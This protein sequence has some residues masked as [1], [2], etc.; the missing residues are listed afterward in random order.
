M[1]YNTYKKNYRRKRTYRRRRPSSAYSMAKRSLYMA[2]KAQGQKELKYAAFP[3]VSGDVINTG[4]I[5]SL[6]SIAQGDTNLTREG[7]VVYPT[8]LRMKFSVTNAGAPGAR[9]FRVIVFKWR[10]DS[11]PTVGDILQNNDPLSFKDIDQRFNSNFIYDRMFKLGTA[12]ASNEKII[13]NIV[14]KFSK[15]TMGFPSATSQANYNSLWCLVISDTA[16]ANIVIAE[17]TSR[18]YFKDA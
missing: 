6:S 3:L 17:A 16:T 12:G 4:Q 7:N 2:K 13:V 9:L 10:P 5:F 1:P 11:T 14:R 18:L 8:S 15:Y